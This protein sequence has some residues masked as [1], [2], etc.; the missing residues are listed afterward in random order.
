MN[1]MNTM[2]TLK[3]V[4]YCETDSICSNTTNNCPD[5]IV[6]NENKKLKKNML[7]WTSNYHLTII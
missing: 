6:L 2:N 3:S 4:N 7:D 1:T 5:D